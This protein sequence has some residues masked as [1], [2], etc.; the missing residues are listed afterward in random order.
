MSFKEKLKVAIPPG[1][2][3]RQSGNRKSSH[4]FVFAYFRGD[5]PRLS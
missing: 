5:Q 3:V 1:Q 2:I 4:R